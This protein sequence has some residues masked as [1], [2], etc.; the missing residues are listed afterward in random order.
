MDKVDVACRVTV[1]GSR[2]R[3][4]V[5]LPAGVPMADLLWDVVEMLG[6]SDGSLPAR[7]ALV[8][9]GGH[10]LDPEQSLSAQGVV[11]GT[12]LFLRDITRRDPPPAIDDYA[13]GVAITVDAQGGRWTKAAAPAMLAGSAASCLAVAGLVLLLAGDHEVRATFG[14]AGAAIS[15]VAALAISQRLNR[16]TFGG[17]I[18][19]SALP[20][21]AAAGA[22]LAG[23]ADAGATS[24]LA[25]ALGSIGVGAAI[26]ILV[27][28]EVVLVPS[29]GIIAVTL[30]PALVV[31]GCA[32]LGA[33]PV[34]AAALLCP[35]ALGSL[36]L[37]ARLT[38]RLAAINHPEPASL[39]ARTRRGRRLLAAL[40][41]GIAVV[42]IAASA[43][44][45]VSGG[46]FAWGL[47][48][49]SAIA[50]T[51]K[52]RHFRFVAEVGPLLAAGVSGLLL[53]EY[54]LIGEFALGPKGTGGA[55]AILIADAL[56]LAAA[57]STVR[58]W[59]LSAQLR[60]QLGR[61]EAIATAATVPLA[62]GV[63]GAYEAVARVVH[64]FG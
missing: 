14:L 15:S 58:R 4:D 41:I 40:L 50:V 47:V 18:A 27:A 54:P 23:F 17:L 57:G 45:A 38:V 56:I 29:A 43:I 20:L 59:E 36:A 48:A 3:L 24:T 42:L 63:L 19:L 49:A 53:L 26:A 44:L 11:S 51:A 1:V 60:R 55:A 61:L 33:G 25:A 64:G 10:V 31:G 39:G 6:E 28:G 62:V 46:W 21:W 30:V 9:V 22:G 35:I 37:P 8:R 7:W 32:V 5:T 2:R 34:A 16:R 12:M 52:A 13:A